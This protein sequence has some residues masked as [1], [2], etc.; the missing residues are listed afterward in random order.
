MHNPPHRGAFI[1]EVCL[2]PNEISCRELVL[3][4][5]ID[6]IAAAHAKI[7]WNAAKYPVNRARGGSK[8]YTKL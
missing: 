5:G 1:Q 7:K 2:A 4:L 8:K 6:L 3:K